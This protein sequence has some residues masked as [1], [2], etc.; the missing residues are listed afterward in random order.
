MRQRGFTLIELLLVLAAGV[1]VLTLSTQTF[2]Q[3]SERGLLTHPMEK[4]S[5]ALQFARVMAV[6]GRRSVSL[7]PSE[8]GHSCADSTGYEQG[9]IIFADD[10]NPGRRDPDEPL[11]TTESAFSQRVTLRSNTFAAFINFRAD[12]RANTNGNF[13][14]CADGHPDGAIG[15]F[16]I[17]SGRLRKA[18]A[19]TIEQCFST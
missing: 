9:W 12:G 17:R 15:I 5:A 4:I 19:G 14:A 7:C 13:V 16:V 3:L 6:G 11:L 10:G 2:K 1:L 8:D 18:P